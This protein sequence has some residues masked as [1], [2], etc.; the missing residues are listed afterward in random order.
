MHT[1]SS[2]LHP[3]IFPLIPPPPPPPLL[4]LKVS[5][6]SVSLPFLRE[7]GEEIY[8][9]FSLSFL[10]LLP[11]FLLSPSLPSFLPPLFIPSFTSPLSSPSL[12][13]LFLSSFLLSFLHPLLSKFVK[14]TP[15]PPP[16]SFFS[17]SFFFPF[18]FSFFLSF[19]PRSPP[20]HCFL[21]ITFPLSL[22]LFIFRSPTP[23]LPSTS[24]TNT[25]KNIYQAYG[26]WRKA[27]HRTGVGR[28]D[29]HK[30]LTV[31]DNKIISFSFIAKGMILLYFTEIITSPSPPH[32]SPCILLALLF[33]ITTLLPFSSYASSS[34][35]LFP[36]PQKRSI[37][38]LLSSLLL[39]FPFCPLHE[40]LF[41]NSTRYLYINSMHALYVAW[42][43][44]Y[45]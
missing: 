19:P 11:S 22:C 39:I 40:I 43:V 8:S 31:K 42:E 9:P 44:A 10:F 28:N 16:L 23:P 4:H 36:P 20:F 41:S 2:F 29:E 12:L 15:S 30:R 24:L 13:T 38:F 14:A 37:Y 6:S 1:I 26:K 45:R 21:F 3:P 27:V 7:K 32:S 5:L 18:P 35:P 33:F 25:R 34:L 17:I